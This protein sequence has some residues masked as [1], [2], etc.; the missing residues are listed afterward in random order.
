MRRLRPA[1][2]RRMPLRAPS[3]FP[4]DVDCVPLIRESPHT[5]IPPGIIYWQRLRGSGLSFCWS[6]HECANCLLGRWPKKCTVLNS[7]PRNGDSALS[8]GHA[9][10]SRRGACP[11]SSIPYPTYPTVVLCVIWHPDRGKQH[12]SASPVHQRKAV[13]RNG[14]E[15][16]VRLVRP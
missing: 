16:G 5:M 9:S 12:F 8:R 3:P 15:L 4:L 6:R 10:S 13:R 11:G 1:P 7:G 2:G 14:A